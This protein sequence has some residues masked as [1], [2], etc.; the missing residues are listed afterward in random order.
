[1]S[2]YWA[3]ICLKT[4]EWSKLDEKHFNLVIDKWSFYWFNNYYVFMFTTW[5]CNEKLTRWFQK[6]AFSSRLWAC[7]WCAQLIVSQYYLRTVDGLILLEI[8]KLQFIF[9]DKKI[10]SEIKFAINY[11]LDDL[12]LYLHK[13]LKF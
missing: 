13:K 7:Y 2:S 8:L 9:L 3:S 11:D 5:N 6:F 10:V 4:D 12:Q 1:M